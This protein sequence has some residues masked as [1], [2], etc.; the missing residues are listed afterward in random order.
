MAKKK[1][2]KDQK[3]LV[4]ARAATRQ[5]ALGAFLAGAGIGT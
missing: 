3:A 4:R 5:I 1:D 2:K